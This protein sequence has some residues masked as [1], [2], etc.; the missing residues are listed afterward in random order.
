MKGENKTKKKLI[1]EL[2]RIRINNRELEIEVVNLR[3]KCR[4]YFE[5]LPILTYK[6]DLDGKI[7][8]CNKLAAE[9]LGYGS[10]E[11]LI[12]GLPIVWT[13]IRFL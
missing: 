6:I 1:D 4:E 9:A 12:E 7:L 11:E 3:F 2:E 5:N 10:K 8:N 13:G